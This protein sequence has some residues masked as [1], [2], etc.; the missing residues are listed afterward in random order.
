MKGKQQEMP[1]GIESS[2]Y[3]SLLLAWMDHIDVGV[4]E[5]ARRGSGIPGVD[6]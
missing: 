6:L 3:V 2:M 1:K 4:A 5:E